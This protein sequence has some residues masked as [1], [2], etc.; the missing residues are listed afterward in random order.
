MAHRTVQQWIDVFSTLPAPNSAEEAIADEIL[1]DL[2]GYR[3]SVKHSH[4]DNVN[5]QNALIA[6]ARLLQE[7][8]VTV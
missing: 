3:F 6:Y 4:G 1:S 2:G 5:L 8:G 7:H